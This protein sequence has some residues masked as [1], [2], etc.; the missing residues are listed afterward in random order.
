MLLK[1]VG[2]AAVLIFIPFIGWAIL[3]L[4]WLVKRGDKKADQRHA[5]MMAALGAD[6]RGTA[7]EHLET[8]DTQ[9]GH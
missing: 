1:V 7:W 5:E 9:P 3:F 6:Y 8:L 4:I 2:F